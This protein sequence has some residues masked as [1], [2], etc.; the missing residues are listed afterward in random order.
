M[1]EKFKTWMRAQWIKVRRGFTALLVTLGIVATAS[2]ALSAVVNVSWQNPTLNEDGSPFDAATE[3][4]ETR[5]YCGVDPLVFV[6]ETPTAPQALTPDAAA[7][8]AATGLQ[9]TKS[10]GRHECFATAVS[11]YGYESRPSDVAIFNVTP[12]VP[13]GKPTNFAIEQQP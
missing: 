11:V 6:P 13:P 2:V 3:L 9:M 5:V 1:L 4:A 7:V 8:G 10:V 12:T